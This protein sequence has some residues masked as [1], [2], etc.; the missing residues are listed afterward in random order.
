MILAGFFEIGGVVGMKLSDAFT[1]RKP[2]VFAAMCMCISFLLLS[3][4]LREIP[5]SIAYGIWTGIGAAGSVLVGMFFFH[6]PKKL[7][8]ILLVSGVILSIV[9]LKF[10]S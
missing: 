9:G 7:L 2:L 3:L 5:I 4:S 1:K 8:K 6:E 10:L